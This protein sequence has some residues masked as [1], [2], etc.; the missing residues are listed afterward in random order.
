[1]ARQRPR[2]HDGRSGSEAQIFAAT[3]ELLS[4]ASLQDITVA[5]ILAEAGISR[6]NFYHY[7]ASKF[8]VLAA[9]VS[10]ILEGTYREDG[11]WQAEPGRPRAK[12]LDASLRETVR[13]WSGHGPVICAALE[14]MYVVPQIAEAWAAMREQFVNAVAEQIEHERKAGRAPAGPPSGTIATMLVCGVERTF[15]VGTR[16]FDPRL[17]TAEDA[18]GPLTEFT[19]AGIYGTFRRRRRSGKATK[20]DAPELDT[21]AELPDW[22]K[23][24]ENDTAATILQAVGELLQEISLDDVS[25]ARICKQS[26][27]SRATFYF[28]FASKEACFAALFGQVVGEV[29]AGFVAAMVQGQDEDE[30]LRLLAGSWLSLAPMDRAVIQA[31]V[32]EWP[33]R[34]EV[35]EIYLDAASRIMSAIEATLRPSRVDPGEHGELASSLFWTMERT[36]AGGLAEEKYLEDSDVVSAALGD[37]MVTVLHSK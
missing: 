18:V 10:N 11:P 13:M 26:G 25:V 15:H 16:G 14:N 19:A 20:S 34:P 27:I 1:M 32:H 7:F 29:V 4:R 28:Y 36:V 24:A 17:P 22:A 21:L 35:R 9:L 30:S 6:A 23:P 12:S 8:D 37:F 31:A 5:D 2:A 3:E 33:R